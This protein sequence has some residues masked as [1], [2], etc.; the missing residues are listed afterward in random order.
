MAS[1]LVFITIPMRERESNQHTQKSQS[2]YVKIMCYLNIFYSQLL[3]CVLNHIHDIYDEYTTVEANIYYIKSSKPKYLE[4]ER[5]KE[6]VK[7]NFVLYTQKKRRR[8]NIY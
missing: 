6:H 2:H 3:L 1:A 4:D 7:A 5:N 8:K